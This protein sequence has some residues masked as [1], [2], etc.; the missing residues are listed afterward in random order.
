MI[1]LGNQGGGKDDVS[2]YNTH[3]FV[4]QVPASDVTRDGARVNGPKAAQRRRRRLVD[5]RAPGDQ[6]QPRQRQAERWKQV[7]R[8]GNPLINEVIIPI[9]QKDKYNA[10]VA[11]RRREELRRST[12]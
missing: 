1:G 3:A 12:R 6:G 4:L 5:H 8:L 7:S 2:G 10:H 9:G 11:R